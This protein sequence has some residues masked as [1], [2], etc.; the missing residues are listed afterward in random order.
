MSDV[1]LSKDA[2]CYWNTGTHASP[3][4]V[5]FSDIVGDVSVPDSMSEQ[6]VTSKGSGGFAMTEVTLQQLEFTLKVFGEPSI[7]LFQTL[8]S[9]YYAR[10]K[11][12]YAFVSGAIATAGTQGIRAFCQV[13]KFERAEQIDGV[14]TY[15][16]T[17]KPCK[18]RESGAIVPPEWMTVS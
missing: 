15:D 17:L 13:T 12:Q 18:Y 14:W 4:W 7:T 11:R 8:R 2:K 9:A 6:D 5:D 16:V 1:I 3:T 10:T